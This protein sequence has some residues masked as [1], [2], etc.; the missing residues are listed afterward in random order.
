MGNFNLFGSFPYVSPSP[1]YTPPVTEHVSVNNKLDA[2]RLCP[3]QYV[4]PPP[5][6]QYMLRPPPP[7]QYVMRPHLQSTCHYIVNHYVKKWHVRLGVAPIKL[8]GGGTNGKDPIYFLIL[9][10]NKYKIINI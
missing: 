7:P 3:P 8:G 6:P 9:F 2:F 4:M 1:R 10:I 5:P